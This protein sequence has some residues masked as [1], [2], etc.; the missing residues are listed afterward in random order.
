MLDR[1]RRFI[2]EW[3]TKVEQDLHPVALAH[4]TRKRKASRDRVVP[5][6]E[7]F[8][9][10]MILL[11]VALVGVI[12]LEALC[13]VVTGAVNSELLSVITGLMGALVAAFVVGKKS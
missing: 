6:S 3:F 4:T 2:S 10:G 7:R 5:P 13:I 12:V 9:W 1:L 11:I 8:V